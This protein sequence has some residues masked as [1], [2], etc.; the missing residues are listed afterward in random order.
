MR[1]IAKAKEAPSAAPDGSGTPNNLPEQLTSFIGRERELSEAAEALGASR[2][3]TMTGAGGCGKTRLAAQAAA[4]QLDRFPD[5]AWWIEL[6]PLADPDAVGAALGDAVGVKPLPGQSSLDA[7]VAHL[8]EARALVVLDNCEHLLEVCA[9]TAEALLHGCPRRSPSSRRAGRRSASP[10]RLTGVCPRSR[11]HRSAR[12]RSP[13]RR[14]PSPMPCAFS[15]SGQERCAP[16]FSR[17]RRQCSD[18]CA[19]SAT[20]SMGFHS[21]SSWQRRVFASSASSE[22]P[23]GWA[24]ASSC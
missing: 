11:C 3:L 4:E 5:G 9:A 14:S 2:L 18:D 10:A 6:A 7:A 15:S 22:S 23:P 13:S 17:R 24:T 21:R 12:R 16:N 1:E 19:R 20:T 8:A